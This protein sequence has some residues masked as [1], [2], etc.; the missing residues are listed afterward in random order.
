MSG[1]DRTNPPKVWNQTRLRLTVA[2]LWTGFWIVSSLAV[3]VTPWLR[4]DQAIDTSQVLPLLV[5]VAS[6]WLPSLSCLVGF[7]F[8]NQP[9]DAKKRN[10]V[11]PEKAIAAII[12]TAI[13]LIFV[14]LVILFPLYWVEYPADVIELPEG[15]SLTER[16]GESVKYAL[17]LSPVALAPINWLTGNASTRETPSR[18]QK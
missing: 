12:L 2:S 11:P 4:R 7:W 3:M 17:L 1:N 15:A 13:Y 16:M 9:P 18:K 14:L 5:Q 8:T 6:V 10:G